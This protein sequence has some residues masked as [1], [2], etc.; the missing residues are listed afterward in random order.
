MTHP[1][2]LAKGQ[3]EI[4]TQDCRA[5]C[6]RYIT[7]SVATPRSREDW[8]EMRWWLAHAGVL[9]TKDEDGWSVHVETR[10]GNLGRGNACD[11]YPHHM[12]T[13]KDYDASHCEFTGPL[14]YDLELESELD[15]ARYLERRKLKRGAPIARAIRRAERARKKA[16]ADGLVTRGG[17]AGSAG[18]RA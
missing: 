3:F 1:A 12:K 18:A 14:D 9:V 5:R 16:A 11:V 10:C 2:P 17:H 6:C 7:I 13:C 4:C 15:L 8:D